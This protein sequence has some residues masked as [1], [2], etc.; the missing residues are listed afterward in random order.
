MST[1]TAPAC[2]SPHL[3]SQEYY[4]LLIIKQKTTK[5]STAIQRFTSFFASIPTQQRRGRNVMVQK[6]L[7][8]NRRRERPTP[9][10][11][12]PRRPRLAAAPCV[13]TV[14][15]TL[16]SNRMMGHCHSSPVIPDKSCNQKSPTIRSWLLPQSKR[17]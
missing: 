8:A 4:L 12:L 11:G 6:S 13:Q 2:C 7:A 10:D 14:G 15:A 1:L 16:S 17:A 5:V 3:I 9:H